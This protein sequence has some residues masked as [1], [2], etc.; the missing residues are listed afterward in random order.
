MRSIGEEISLPRVHFDCTV[1]AYRVR[2]VIVDKRN[3]TV[4]RILRKKELRIVSAR[5]LTSIMQNAHKGKDTGLLKRN[6]DVFEN[7]SHAVMGHF[8]DAIVLDCAPCR[9]GPNFPKAPH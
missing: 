8:P 7:I 4:G 1:Q 9:C 5:L 6:V 3:E 2:R